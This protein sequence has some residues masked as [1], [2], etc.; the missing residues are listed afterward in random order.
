MTTL[1]ERLLDWVDF[2]DA[3]HELGVVLGLWMP[4][5]FQEHKWVFWSK[6]VLGEALH[7]ALIALSGPDGPLE[8]DQEETRFRW[9]ASRSDLRDEDRGVPVNIGKFTQADIIEAV[10]RCFPYSGSVR[11]IDMSDPSAVRFTWRRERFHVSLLLCVETGEG[12]CFAH[13]NSA[14]L[15]ESVIKTAMIAIWNER[16]KRDK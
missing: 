12:P 10:M 6:N 8:Y 16:S 3:A 13:S 1:R 2:D 9:F 5:T 11:D 15:A 7:T 4:G 14:I